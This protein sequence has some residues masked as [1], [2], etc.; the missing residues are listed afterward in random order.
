MHQAARREQPG[1]RVGRLQDV[2]EPV[3][4]A[5]PVAQRGRRALAQRTRHAAPGLGERRHAV[6]AVAAEELVGALTRER[7]RDLAA[8]E[9]AEGQEAQRG[10]VGERL[11]EVPHEAREL[12]RV[13]AHR[14]LELVVVGAVPRGHAAR[15]A[16]LGVLAREAHREGL[17]G[18]AHVPPHERD[19]QA[20]VEA[21]A[22]H[23]AERHV[24]HEAHAH[25]LVE[26]LEQQLGPFVRRA[27]DRVRRRRRIAPP[28]LDRGAPARDHQ[29]LT[30]L[31][32][33]DLPERRHRS[34]HVSEGQV[35]GY[36]LRV[37][38]IAH[39]AAGQDGL[40]LGAEHHDVAD[41]RV[42]EGLDPQAVADQHSAPLGAVPDRQR[43]HPAQ[44]LGEC[45]TVV[46]VEVRQDLRVAAAS[47]HV[48][49]PAQLLAQGRVVVDL[50]VLCG[51]D[52]AAL[53][54]EGLVAA[55]H[56]D[57]REPPG[58]ERAALTGHVAGVVRAAV[59]DHVGHRPQDGV[60]QRG[61]AGAIDPERAGNPA[62]GATVDAATPGEPSQPCR[63][64][65]AE[66][67]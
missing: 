13:A 36:R 31:Q 23:G 1:G 9:L 47:Q 32:L 37:E 14:H 15:V 16:E 56:V 25:G 27:R 55:L 35:G 7:D 58:A 21:A 51:P 44:P 20:R 19:D 18:L 45:G 11:V 48:A 3:G 41:Q 61:R 10:E 62:H 39:Q 63:T 8:R 46:L 49:A 66:R 54:G 65:R 24:A 60:R 33:P 4:A 34:R 53:V 5:R 6:L 26:L 52:P 64:V 59:G 50:T 22:Q 38:L 42:V 40:Q 12:G 29:P 57:D 67:P 17:D 43:E 28:A 30:R 2:H